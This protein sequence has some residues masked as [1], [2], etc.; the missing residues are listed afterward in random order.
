MEKKNEKTKLCV[1]I[2]LSS[3]MI[4]KMFFYHLKDFL[5]IIL[6]LIACKI[7]T[8]ILMIVLFEQTEMKVIFRILKS[9]D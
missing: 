4:Y 1:L 7:F 9:M 2:I 6:D 5:K 3:K 8:N